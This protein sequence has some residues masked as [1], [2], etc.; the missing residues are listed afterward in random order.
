ML[1]SQLTDSFRL[2]EVGIIHESN[3]TLCK[4]LNVR[5]LMQDIFLMCLTKEE[6]ESNFWKIS[7]TSR[8]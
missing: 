2:K 7:E 1:Q 4:I 3:I 6:L 8:D 5:Y